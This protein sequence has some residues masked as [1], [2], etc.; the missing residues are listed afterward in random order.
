MAAIRHRRANAQPSATAAAT[1]VP[2]SSMNTTGLQHE[3]E[4]EVD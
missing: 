4:T 3:A 1:S 2:Q